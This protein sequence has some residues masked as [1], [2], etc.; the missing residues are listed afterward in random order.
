MKQLLLRVDDELHGQ[1]AHRAAARG[2]SVNALAN[3]L[4][5]ASVDSVD[6]SRKDRL[7]LRLIAVGE[8]GSQRTRRPEIVAPD[9]SALESLRGAGAIAEELMRFE[10]S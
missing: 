7:T 3:A 4:L 2:I 5:N 6:L 1:L 8:V 10:R 9:D